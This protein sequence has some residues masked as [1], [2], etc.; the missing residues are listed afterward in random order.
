VPS[1]H[2]TFDRPTLVVGRAGGALRGGVHHDA[3]GDSNDRFAVP[4]A[5][6]AGAILTMMQAV[7]IEETS[8]GVG[9]GESSP[10]MRPLVA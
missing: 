4:E 3:G 10:V 6:H 7:G 1:S 5:L 8:F 2:G 9:I